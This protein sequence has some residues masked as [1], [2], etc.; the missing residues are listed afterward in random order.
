VGQG[1]LVVGASRSHTQTRTLG[2]SPLDEFAVDAE[3]S[4]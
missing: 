4:T 2:R 3:T 1:L